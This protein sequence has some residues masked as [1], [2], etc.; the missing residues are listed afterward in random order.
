[1]LASSQ[2]VGTWN[3]YNSYSTINRIVETPSK[4][5]YLSDGSLYGYNP[6]TEEAYSYDTSMGLTESVISDIYYN[7]T[8]NY[9]AIAYN[10]G[11]IDLLY[12][13]TQRVINM[14]DIK[15][16]VVNTA[17]TI[18]DIDFAPG[19]MIVST[20]FGIVI[21]D[22]KKHEVIESAIFN[23]PVSTASFFGDNIVWAYN[24][25]LYYLPA[26]KRMSNL[27]NYTK[28]SGQ[29]NCAQVRGL[30]ADKGIFTVTYNPNLFAREMTIT[31]GVVKVNHDK[32]V[33]SNM[34][35]LPQRNK[36][37]LFFSSTT[38]KTSLQINDN[39]FSSPQVVNLSDDVAPDI[40]SFYDDM[41]VV[42]RGN[43]DGVGRY[44]LAE[45][46]YVVNPIKPNSVTFTGV[47]RI[48]AV[49]D[50]GVIIQ[51]Y[52]GSNLYSEWGALRVKSYMNLIKD[53]KIIDI[54][55]KE[56]LPP[57]PDAKSQSFKFIVF[58]PD[59][60]STYY[61]SSLI[62]GIYK[63][64]GDE[65]LYT[66]TSENSSLMPID[67]S[68]SLSTEYSVPGLDIDSHGNLWAHQMHQLYSVPTIHV[69][70][71]EAR[72]RGSTT[73]SDWQ[74][75][76]PDNFE[77]WRDGILVAC[78]KND[79]V[80]SASP[81]DRTIAV[82][83]SKGKPEVNANNTR[84]F[85]RIIDQDNKE[86]VV[87]NIMVGSLFEDSKGRIWMGTLQ[88]GV[89]VVTNHADFF[90]SGKVNHV[91]V[92]RNDGTNY[93]DYLLDNVAVFTIEED[94]A[95]R[96]WFG[97]DGGV[98]LVSSDLSNIQ[99]LE[100][101]DTNNSPLMSDMVYAIRQ[102]KKSN[103]IFFGTPNGLVSLLSDS[104]AP[105]ED[106]NEVIIYPNPV[107]PDYNGWVTIKGLMD[108]SLVKI[109][110]QAGNQIFEGTSNGGMIS[111]NVCDGRGQKVKT[112][113]YYVFASQNANGS[114]SGKLVGKVMVV[115]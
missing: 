73:P 16:A 115:K 92:P 86:Y 24:K 101:Y 70:S 40:I 99:V 37:G 105:A 12:D 113:V 28:I 104:S 52:G 98:Y 18:N 83:D 108:G 32:N 72:K 79:Y 68:G 54:M 65:V 78:K 106:Y 7:P 41:N 102:D 30:S 96:M 39:N 109:T 94:N 87:G 56:L 36:N 55:P 44:N 6:T 31:D 57:T 107:R 93:A 3:I 47:G 22:D 91:K 66:F 58:D 50:G 81:F 46:K 51:N 4:V 82:V 26:G 77:G 69:L 76:L 27:A 62:T 10:S 53:G 33:A 59:D 13:T 80:Y 74:S 48:T 64:K 42:W 17:R 60:P 29:Y 25:D 85:S 114:A 84:S 103:E 19:K 45:K 43:K 15:D 97:T 1:M 71:S 38:S 100:H 95:G 67:R 14:P 5:Y 11:N 49:P 21:F 35:V 111:W 75:I 61:I 23:T 9:I 63:I 110:D 34:P 2:E 8:G 90:N 89:Y 88:G 112:G 20:N